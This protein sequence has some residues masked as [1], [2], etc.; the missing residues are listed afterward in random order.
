MTDYRTVLVERTGHVAELRLN[1]PDTLNAFDDALINELPSVLIDLARDSAV[2]SVVLTSTGRH[3]SAGGD[4]DTIVAGHENLNTLMRGVDDGRRLFRAFT[5]FP[6]P[7]V[8]A[9]H[10]RC[11]GVAT[12]LV[13]TADAVVAAPDAVLSDPH[14]HMGLVAGD[15]GCVAWPLSAGLARAKRQLLWGEPVTGRQAYELGLI[16][17]LAD[18]DVAA[19]ELAF[20]L[21]GRVASLPPVAVQL[22]KRSL[23]RVLATRTDAVL[24][25]SFYLEALSNRSADALEAV[26]A[27]REKREGRWTGS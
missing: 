2:R 12:S 5:D 18:D 27:F 26:N 8:V 15:G 23:N 11:F 24:D 16:S 19:R 3:F 6:K 1:R 4:L 25:T 13:L 9:L 20:E 7:L 10:G 21:A 14:V 22:T 17:D